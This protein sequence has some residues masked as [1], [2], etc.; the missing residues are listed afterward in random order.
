MTELCARLR[1]ISIFQLIYCILFTILLGAILE[2]FYPFGCFLYTG[3]AKKTKPH[4]FVH[5]FAKY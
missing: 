3:W 4:T 5:I 2:G 1:L